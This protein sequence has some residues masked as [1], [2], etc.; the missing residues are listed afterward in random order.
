MERA[1]YDHDLAQAWADVILLAAMQ[2]DR[3]RS[4]KILILISFSVLGLRYVF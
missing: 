3:N 4:N 1:I 2:L